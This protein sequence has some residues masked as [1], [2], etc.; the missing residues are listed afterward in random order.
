MKPSKSQVIGIAALFAAS[1][2]SCRN[3][4]ETPAGPSSSATQSGCGNIQGNGNTV[5][6]ITPT[7]SPSPS[8]SGQVACIAQTAP[9]TCVKGSPTLGTILES[10][11]ATVAPAP[12]AIYVAN[13]VAALNKDPRVCAI[14][15][16]P[17]A[18]D[19]VAIK[20]RVSNAQS[21]TF[22]VVNANGS[23]QTLPAQPFNICL[24]SR[25]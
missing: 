24:P 2:V 17:L 21:E 16:P 9:Y 19:E 4:T 3:Q 22:D 5:N 14:S 13:L 25:F 8:P 11:Q 1:L 15:G 23:I 18:P 12:E 7:P 10:V 6:C 20:A